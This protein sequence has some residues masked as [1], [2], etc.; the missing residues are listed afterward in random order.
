[1]TR[2]ERKGEPL[3]PRLVFLM[4]LV[5]NA[6]VASAVIGVSVLGGM[7]GYHFTESMSWLD[8][9]A[10]A[11]MIASGMGPLTPMQ[12]EAGKLFAGFYALYSGLLL[13]GASSLI[14]APV[15]HRVM[16]RLHVADDEDVEPTS[17][18]RLH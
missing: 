5:G 17:R 3:A 18:R 1:M 12:T 10:N 13:V 14:L 8:A 7:A 16:H 11:A 15:F 4:R 6:V 9:F 2:Y